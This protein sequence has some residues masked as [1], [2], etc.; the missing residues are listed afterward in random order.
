MAREVGEAKMS[1]DTEN[2]DLMGRVSVHSWLSW[3]V[4]GG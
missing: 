3:K 4:W 1:G 2:V